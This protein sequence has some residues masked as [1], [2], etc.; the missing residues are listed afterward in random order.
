[1]S[2][3]SRLFNTSTTSTFNTYEVTDAPQMPTTGRARNTTF[4]PDE[5]AVEYRNG[6]FHQMRIAGPAVGH[7]AFRVIRNIDRERD[8]PEWARTYLGEDN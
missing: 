1:M 4:Q 6:R 2:F 5:V 7:E 3:L 8:V